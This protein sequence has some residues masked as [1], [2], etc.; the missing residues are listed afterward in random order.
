MT[1]PKWRAW[2]ECIGATFITAAKQSKVSRIVFL[3]NTGA[4]H[5]GLGPISG[6][7]AVERAP[8]AALPNVVV[9]RAGSC[10]ENTFGSLP[11]IASQ[12]AMYV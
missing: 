11:T 6:T 12:G 9:V 10:T 5:E 8:N 1:E 2:P 3:S 7:G 4:Q